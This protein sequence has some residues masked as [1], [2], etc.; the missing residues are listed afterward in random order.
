MSPEPFVGYARYKM[1]V[2]CRDSDA[3]PKVDRA[4]C[5]VVHEGQ[6]VQ[7][8]HNGV[9]VV[10]DGYHGEWM[11]HVI[12]DLRGHHEPQEEWAFH[13]ILGRIASA[14][15]T[16]LEL[17]GYWAYYSL[18]FKRRFP[19]GVNYVAEPDPHNLALGQRNFALNG[20]EAHFLQAYV[21]A[22]PAPQ[23]AF[24]CESD[25]AT[26]LVDRLSVDAFL[27]DHHLD[28]LDILHCDTQGGE[29]PML[30]GAR[31][32]LT[33][34]RV[35]FVVISTH[36]HT[37]TGDALTHQRCL[38]LVTE[39]GGNILVEHTV[40]ESFSGD[41]LIVVSFAGE[42]RGV[43]IALSRN[44]AC[45][46]VVFRETEY[47]L[48]EEQARCASLQR[49]AEDLQAR[50]RAAEDT[51]REQATAVE[52][53]RTRLSASQDIVR[54]QQAVLDDI[55]AYQATRAY[56]LWRRYQTAKAAILARLP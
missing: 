56:R 39:Y 10:A 11:R 12:H 22:T 18:W 34:G 41:G 6:A 44:R 14:R 13:E 31:E 28:H 37:I 33:G 20:Y 26:R 8:M 27:Q 29:L 9:R 36:H 50:L 52:R 16:M 4:G 23:Q 7:V 51:I 15:P 45:A 24:V 53:E 30:L 42:D 46:N 17:G 2:S 35:R 55:E 3:I 1:T 21:G 49:D 43:A 19:R 25:N 5:V 32:S 48:A 40:G 47:D 54:A 38:N